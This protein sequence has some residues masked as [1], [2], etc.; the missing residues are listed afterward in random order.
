MTSYLIYRHGSNAANQ[1]MTPVS[2]VGIVDAESPEEARRIAAENINCYNNQHL[3]L[4]DEADLTEDQCEDWNE[5]VNRSAELR[6]V[7]EDS[8]IFS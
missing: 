5:V 1:S 6:A 7:G 8:L 4:I 2:A 3:S